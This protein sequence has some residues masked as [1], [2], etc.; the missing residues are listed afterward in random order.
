MSNLRRVPEM[1]SGRGWDLNPGCPSLGS[2]ALC[3]LPFPK[4]FP[5]P[6]A[7]PREILV[8]TTPAGALVNPTTSFPTQGSFPSEISFGPHEKLGNQ[9]LERSDSKL[10]VIHTVGRRQRTSQSCHYSFHFTDEKTESPLFFTECP[11]S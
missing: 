5:A 2:V 3:S 11:T 9:G 10:K 1:V 8:R 7:P 6:P 4:P